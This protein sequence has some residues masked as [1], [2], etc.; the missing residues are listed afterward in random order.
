[1]T[2]GLWVTGSLSCLEEQLPRTVVISNKEREVGVL[3]L[4]CLSKDSPT[5]P[6][7]LGVSTEPLA[8]RQY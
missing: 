6:A 5:S 1:V 4:A 7:N 8:L 2:M 3:W